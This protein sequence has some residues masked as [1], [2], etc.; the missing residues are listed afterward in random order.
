MINLPERNSKKRSI[1]ITSI[2]DVHLTIRQLE[3][4]LSDYGDYIDVSKFGVGT[5]Y[6]T[7]KLDEKISVLRSHQVEAYFGG[8]LFEKFYSEGKIDEYLIFLDRHNIN[9]IEISNGTIEIPLEDRLSLVEKLAKNFNVLSEVGSK[10]DFIIMAPSQWTSEINALINA[11]AKYVITEG[12]NSGTAGIYRQS[13]EMRTGLIEDIIKSCDVNKIIFEAPSS[14]AQ[15]YF[16]NRLGANVNLGN[17]DPKD[18]LLLETQRLG[19]RSETFNL[20]K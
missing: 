18:L 3:D 11:G 8:T 9:T 7:K 2:H 17:V 5:A 19:L 1:G 20:A 12:R 14:K 13:G 6:V 4:I 10:D 16:I 15:M